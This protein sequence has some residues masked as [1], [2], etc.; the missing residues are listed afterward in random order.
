MAE[1]VSKRQTP[2]EVVFGIG[3]SALSPGQ[4]HVIELRVPQ[5]VNLQALGIGDDSRELGPGIISI[6]FCRRADCG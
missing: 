6:A 5:T 1:I 2:Q 3:S 4:P